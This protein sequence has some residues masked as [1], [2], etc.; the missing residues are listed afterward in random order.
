MKKLFF[1]FFSIET[2][3]SIVRFNKEKAYSFLKFPDL[4][5][6]FASSCRT[7]PCLWK[8][9]TGFL[10]IIT[11]LST[12]G[13]GHPWPHFPLHSPDPLQGVRGSL[14]VN[15][16]IKCRAENLPHSPFAHTLL[17]QVCIRLRQRSGSK[18][19]FVS[20]RELTSMTSQWGCH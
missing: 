10:I 16:W 8:P 18:G 9:Q 2:Q 5:N 14:R 1:F 3:W 11:M 19:I 4:L 15:K 6:L 12:T 13:K 17:A 20:S 7:T